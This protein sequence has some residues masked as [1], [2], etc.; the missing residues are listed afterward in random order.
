MPEYSRDNVVSYLRVPNCRAHGHN[1]A[2]ISNIP[3]DYVCQSYVF[4]YRGFSRLHTQARPP[5][6][7]EAEVA[8][9]DHPYDTLRVS[10]HET[11]GALCA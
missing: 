10:I 6:L 7:L 4:F 1:H 3:D 5:V 2:T 8:D 11:P 9:T